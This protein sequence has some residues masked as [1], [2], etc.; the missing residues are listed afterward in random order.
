MIRAEFREKFAFGS[1]RGI[2]AYIFSRSTNA[3]QAS[4]KT[5]GQPTRRA[6][7]RVLPGPPRAAA[8]CVCRH[9][10]RGY[11]SW[12]VLGGW[13]SPEAPHRQQRRACSDQFSG[14]SRHLVSARV[15]REAKR[16][17]KLDLEP[18]CNFLWRLRWSALC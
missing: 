15:G 4:P 13:R 17:E 12:D 1:Y 16:D 18:P 8:G 3:Q 14:R 7:A 5:R 11:N 10:R 9:R 6:T 2:I